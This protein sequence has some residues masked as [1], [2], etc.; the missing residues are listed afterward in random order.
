MDRLI[1]LTAV[2]ISQYLHISKH[3]VIYLEYIQ[4]LYVNYTSTKLGEKHKC[5][6]NMML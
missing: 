4:I 1:S 3:Q 5:S 6:Q 2:I